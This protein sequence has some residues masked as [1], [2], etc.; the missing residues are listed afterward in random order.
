[1][2]DHRL[3]DHVR[4]V[5]DAGRPRGRSARTA[6]G[7]R[8]RRRRV[9]D[10]LVLLRACLVRG[11]ADRLARRSGSRCRD[12][13]PGG[14]LDHHDDVQRG[15]RAEQGARDLGRDRRRRRGGRCARGRRAHEVPRLGMDLLRQRAGR[16]DRA[17]ADTAVRPRE[18]RRARVEPGR[19]GRRCGHLRS[20]PAR[21]CGLDRADAPL[22]QR[23]NASPTRRRQ[24]CCWSHSS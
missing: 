15:R 5:P 13:L 8:R 6:Q 18:P 9:H 23:E 21:L 2:G 14:A 16:S 19:R 20:R 3:R 10:R 11:R 22:G 4:R 12:H 7:L 17:G 24:S 1:M